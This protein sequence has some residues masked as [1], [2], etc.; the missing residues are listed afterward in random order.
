MVLLVVGT[1]VVVLG[2][3]CG[4][5]LT[6]APLGM[7]PWSPELA[8]WFLFPVLCVGGYMLFG[9]A[10]KTAQVRGFTFVVSCA[11]LLLALASAA[12]VV[13]SAASVV[14]PAGSLMS[15]WYVLAVAGVLG[16]VGVAS[17][18]FAVAE[19]ESHA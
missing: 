17:S 6:L 16:S 8:L 11:L 5:V 9:M 2:L 12:G 3:F 10:G 7:V 1:F 4:V 14:K 19:R 13:L 15:L 18:R